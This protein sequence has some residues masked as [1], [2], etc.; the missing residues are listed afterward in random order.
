MR[1]ALTHTQ[2]LAQITT[3]DR[4]AY[5]SLCQAIPSYVLNDGLGLTVAFVESKATDTNE[6]HWVQGALRGLLIAD[7]NETRSLSTII[8]ADTYSHTQYMMDTFTVLDAWV[9]YKRFAKTLLE[10]DPTGVPTDTPAS[11]PETGA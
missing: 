3:L 1:Q 9:F 8:A 2:Q 4:S 7:A 11:V 5:I 6:Y 10:N